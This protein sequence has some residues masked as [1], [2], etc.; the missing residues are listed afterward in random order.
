MVRGIDLR[1]THIRAA[2]GRDIYIP[3]SRLFKEPLVNYTRDRLRRL[4]FTIGI[5]YGDDSSRARELVIEAVREVPGVLSDPA[6]VAMVS[7]FD[8]NFVQLEIAVWADMFDKGFELIS[9]RN[10]AVE[11]CR[12]TLADHGF[13]FRSNVSTN[14]N[15]F[16]PKELDVAVAGADLK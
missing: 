11:T 7:S 16:S 9:V 1:S 14:L 13:T 6:P 2:D 12:R 3:S 5:D 4:S 10:G 15:L 8:A